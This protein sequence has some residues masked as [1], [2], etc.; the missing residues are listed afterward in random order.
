[1]TEGYETIAGRM[2]T[3]ALINIRYYSDIPFTEANEITEWD[4]GLTEAG[5]TYEDYPIIYI[6]NDSD[7]MIYNAKVSSVWTSDQVGS[8]RDT[9][10]QTY[11]ACYNNGLLLD[12][13]IENAFLI[14]GIG[15][16]AV[17]SAGGILRGRS[18]AK[19][20]VVLSPDESTA[21]GYKLWRI[22]VTG[23][24]YPTNREA[25]TINGHLH[26]HITEYATVPGE[27]FTA[28]GYK[29]LSGY[30]NTEAV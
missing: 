17:G 4:F 1:M 9:I 11:F 2:N 25:E 28:G 13:T 14:C 10:Q 19:I 22:R 15:N 5:I 20:A 7:Y 6:Y 18:Y 29:T 8:Y 24:Y 26:M 21:S 3:R 23:N 30:L 27:M 16:N 12:G